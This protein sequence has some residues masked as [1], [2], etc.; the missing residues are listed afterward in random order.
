[1]N[2]LNSRTLSILNSEGIAGLLN[3]TISRLLRK[4]QLINLCVLKLDYKDIAQLLPPTI[5]LQIREVTE[6]DDSDTEALAKFGFYGHS[7]VEILQY[8]AERQ[9]CC[10]AKHEG[11]AISCYWCRTRDFYDYYLKRRFY[12]AGNEEYILGAF[13]LAEF[14]GKG[15]LPYLIAESSRERVQNYPNLRAIV[16][17]RVN[18]KASLRSFHK[19]GFTIIGR[20]GFVEI[21][22]IRFHFLLGRNALPKTTQRI[23]LQI[24]Q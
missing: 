11:Q 22:G 1:M 17:V 18:N 14:R 6:T 24:F 3:R 2:Q 8:L 10:V 15:I 13:T 5:D 4:P 19:L 7:K 20:V 9:Q 12:L 16:F 23:F 21:F